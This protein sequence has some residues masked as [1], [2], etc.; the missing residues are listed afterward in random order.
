MIRFNYPPDRMFNTLLAS[1]KK[2]Y[3]YILIDIE[4]TCMQELKS[5]HTNFSRTVTFECEE[6]NI[7]KESI[8]IINLEKLYYY[9]HD[10]YNDI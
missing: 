4:K 6:S 10:L 8:S 2:I 9:C 5:I 1:Q 7:K 3:I